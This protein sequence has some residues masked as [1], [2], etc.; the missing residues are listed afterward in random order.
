MPNTARIV[1]H[2][3]TS[4][5]P[6][7]QPVYRFDVQMFEADRWSTVHAGFTEKADAITYALVQGWALAQSIL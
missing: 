3:Q 6:D 1:A 7:E 5:I 2:T 4:G